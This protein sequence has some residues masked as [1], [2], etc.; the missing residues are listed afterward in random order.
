[1]KNNLFY[2]LLLSFVLFGFIFRYVGMQKNLSYW[3]DES[4]TALR[5]RGILEYGKPVTEIGHSTGLYQ[6]AYY[7]LTALSFTVFG[8]NEFAGRIP[9]VFVGTFLIV[10]V[11]FITKKIVRDERV[12][13]LAAF[14]TG[15]SQIQL[16][17]STQLRPYVWLELFVLISAY[18]SYQFLQNKKLFLDKNI[19]MGL[20]WSVLA[21]LFHGSGFIA[22]ALIIY[23]MIT[24]IIQLK[25]YMYLLILIPI[26]LLLLILLKFSNVTIAHMFTFDFRICHTHPIFHNH[27]S[28]RTFLS[29]LLK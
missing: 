11:F 2:V 10:A 17:W 29:F 23:V 1:M 7:Y 9:S 16:A 20:F 26:V 14:L 25:K 13:I 22:V 3:N 4:H 15:F 19:V 28:V 12:A 8:V 27:N 24:K 21:V 6:I 5:S 18:Y